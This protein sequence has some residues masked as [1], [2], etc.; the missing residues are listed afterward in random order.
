M[1]M[2]SFREY[3]EQVLGT[4]MPHGNISGDW[5]VKYGIPLI[6]RCRCCDMTMAIPSAWIDDEGYTYCANCADIEECK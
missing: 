4:E 1:K 6:V 2:K 5:F 3:V